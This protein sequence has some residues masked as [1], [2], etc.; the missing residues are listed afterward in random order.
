[1][2][3]STVDLNV[4]CQAIGYHGVRA[5]TLATLCALQA[6]H[7]KAIPFENLDVLAGQV[8]ALD[9]ASLQR[10][11]LGHGRGG[12]CFEHNTLFW[13][14][15]KQLGFKVS[16]LAA[17]VRRRVPADQTTPLGHMALRVDLDDMRYLVDVGYG[18][19]TLTTPLS[20]DSAAAQE[21]THEACRI[22]KLHDDHLLQAEL[23][24]KW[25]PL[26]QFELRTHCAVDFEVWNWFT[27]TSPKS[28]FVN[29]LMAARTELGRRHALLGNRYTE[30][31]LGGASASTLL[32]SA[33]E[34]RE[35]LET[36]FGIRVPDSP[37]LSAKLQAIATAS[38]PL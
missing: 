14:V 31:V 19:L 37:V 33:A 38:E 15:L 20:L 8:V 27:C 6:A 2:S 24:G 29:T 21:T 1:M 17:R 26:Y 22:V 34:L 3:E 32:S 5:P 30:H 13:Q 12:F 4:Y 23:A 11:L 16:A 28:P 35:V 7:A 10:K 18:G 36:R 25:E 9:L